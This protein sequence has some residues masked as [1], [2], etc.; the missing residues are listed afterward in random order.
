M[1]FICPRCRRSGTDG[2]VQHPLEPGEV[3][4]S[5]GDFVLEGFLVC[6]NSQCRF[7]YPILKGVPVILKDLKGWLYFEQSKL[8]D[9]A[10]D[11]D[12]MREYLAG[13]NLNETQG[14]AER[15]LLSVYM[16]F[17]YGTPDDIPAAFESFG[18]PK[19]FWKKLVE[20]AQP[21]KGSK[22]L[23]AL[24]LGCSVGRYTFELARFSNLAVGIDLKFNALSY[25][26]RFQRA[27]EVSYERKRHGRYFEKIQSAYSPAQNVLFIA[28]DAL[29]PPFCAETFDFVA[30]LNLLDN[31]RLPLVLIGQMD[32]LLKQGGNLVI[33][34]PYEWRADLC[35]P[36]EWLDTYELDGPGMVRNI[37]QGKVFGEM[38]LKYDMVQEIMDV[39]WMLRHHKRHWSLFLI[40]LLKAFKKVAAV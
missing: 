38:G 21:E 32:A 6:S 23:F 28:A 5:D 12:E 3:L 35:E 4:K 16:D 11:T 36:S 8:S 9:V 40:H 18:D 26:A 25:A 22:Y 34:S 10:G 27:Q 33:G 15:S 2:I 31:V 19:T 13:L 17:H 14:Y 24:D 7:S 20:K 37:L 30:S 1:E 39:P 29:D